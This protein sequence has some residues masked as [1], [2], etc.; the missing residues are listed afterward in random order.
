MFE[1]RPQIVLLDLMM[2]KMNGLDVLDRIIEVAV[3]IT[4]PQLTR[5]PALIGS[6]DVKPS[7]RPTTVAST[8]AFTGVLSRGWTDDSRRTRWPGK[9][10]SRDMA[11]V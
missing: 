11:N 9:F 5:L 10:P 4:D 7:A 8:I 1:R 3:V 6:I 2:P